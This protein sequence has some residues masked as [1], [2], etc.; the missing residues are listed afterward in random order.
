MMFIMDN[1]VIHSGQV[2]SRF[3]GV[4]NSIFCLYVSMDFEW[5]QHCH[6]HVI[7]FPSFIGGRR[8]QAQAIAFL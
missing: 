6:G 1:A 7:T 8:L 4:K 3:V 2:H 5:R